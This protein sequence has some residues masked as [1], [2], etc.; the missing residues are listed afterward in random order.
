MAV[1]SEKLKICIVF[2]FT[3]F[4]MLLFS[5]DSLLYKFNFWP[6][7][8]LY[9]I[10]GRALNNGKELYKDLYDTKGPF[11]IFLYQVGNFISD[12]TFVGFWLMEVLCVFC[13]A[14]FSYRVLCIK[15][16]GKNISLIY[17][18]L[19]SLLYVTCLFQTGVLVVE[20]MVLAILSY[21]LYVYARI[22]YGHSV[23]YFSYFLIG[24]LSAF[25]LWSKFNYC[26]Y[27]LIF[28]IAF[29]LALRK[30]ES[31]IFILKRLAV[32]FLGLFL[33]SLIIICKHGFVTL[34]DEYFFDM[35]R[36]ASGGSENYTLFEA[37]FR[38][39]LKVFAYFNTCCLIFIFFKFE[40]N[41]NFKRLFLVIYLVHLFTNII[42]HNGILY[43]DQIYLLSAVFAV[44]FFKHDMFDRNFF[45]S[46]PSFSM[47][48]VKW[49][50]TI[51]FCVCSII[52]LFQSFSLVLYTIS[53]DR[54]P[55][56]KMAEYIRS[57]SED[58]DIVFNSYDP[59]DISVV[60]IL[61]A[62][63]HFKY[64]TVYGNGGLHESERLSY[65]KEHIPDF[66]ITDEDDTIRSYDG[67][68]MVSGE[69]MGFSSDFN[70]KPPYYYGFL[71]EY[72][73]YD[74]YHVMYLWERIY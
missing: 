71:N 20:Q 23:S 55:Q 73:V 57:R 54:V 35:F 37:I 36:Y 67:Y 50:F 44:Y 21:L 33:V 66:I 25:I 7:V 51:L 28:C 31:R 8:N 19:A 39:A 13:Y 72:G 52:G 16:Q 15:N 41:K 68:R 30:T 3:V 24:I 26:C 9:M 10:L 6:D 40:T 38:Q 1:R 61:K 45:K 47:L 62:D 27:L 70:G 53:P 22:L 42:F 64:F 58:P 59:M 12:D 29:I 14:Y 60:N 48:I 17:P 2:L 11:W 18:C 65:I 49:M 43:Y 32:V 4:I 46:G 34:M 56:Y 5:Y 63:L 69:E 74:K